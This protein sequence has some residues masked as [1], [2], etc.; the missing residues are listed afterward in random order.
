VVAVL[1]S[2]SLEPGQELDDDAGRQQQSDYANEHGAER[3][4]KEAPEQ[5]TVGCVD[6][7]LQTF[8]NHYLSSY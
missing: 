1:I 5:E 2:E 6:D 8:N 7:P 3:Q 4:G